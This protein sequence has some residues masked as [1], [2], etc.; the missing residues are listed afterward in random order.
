MSL[1][2]PTVSD[3]GWAVGGDYRTDYGGINV[4]HYCVFISG[5]SCLQP[6]TSYFGNCT[7]RC[8]GYGHGAPPRYLGSAAPP[9]IEPYLLPYIDSGPADIWAFPR[10][11]SDL[12][13]QSA[14]CSHS[15]NPP[16]SPTFNPQGFAFTVAG[17]GAAGF[18]DGFGSAAEFSGPHDVAVDAYGYVYVADTM[19]NAIRGI[20]PHGAV[21]TIAGQGPSSKGYRD[22]NC[23]YALFSQ[24]KGIEVTRSANN[25]TVFVADT[26]NNRIRVIHIDNSTGSCM[27]SCL[28]GLCYDPSKETNPFYNQAT[29]LAGL[30]DG[31]PYSSRFSSPQGIALLHWN[32]TEFIV[33][34]DTGNFL[35]RLVNSSSGYATTLAGNWTEDTSDTPPAGCLAP[36]LVGVAGRRDGN[37]S[38][39]QFYTPQYV[40]I[41]SNATVFVT[42]EHRIR[43]IQ[44]PSTLSD[45][46]G[47]YS[48]GGVSTIAGTSIQGVEDGKGIESS[49][50]DPTGIFVTSDNV[51]YV[52]DAASC[53]IRRVSPISLVAT[54]INCS[55]NLDIVFRPS[56]CTSYDP[57]VD[58]T[59][60]KISRV[61][62]NTIYNYGFP[63]SND[64]D[65]GKYIKDC[66]GSP[67]V[68]LL[69]KHYLYVSGDN[70]V[71]DDGVRVVDEDAEQGTAI[72][73]QC[74]P[75]CLSDSTVV[76]GK[77]VY[78]VRSSICRAGIH[79]GV[80][81][82]QGGI[83][84]VI[85]GR[86]NSS[87]ANSVLGATDNGISSK[88][89]APFEQRVFSLSKE[90]SATSFVHSIAGQPAA[91][92][93]DG[94]GYDDG[95]PAT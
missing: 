14:A 44:L 28:S 76:E 52:S 67:P 19:N 5:G 4:S 90:D 1:N 39:A 64:T 38:Y 93:Q 48:H 22:G 6:E 49:F 56:G 23:S 18:K 34:A 42:D 59:G 70:L 86:I 45:F 73:V 72:F 51:A 40:S 58:L 35:I 69:N 80:I 24:P 53:H 27:V 85:L 77:G 92:L 8:F 3:I 31:P 71:V 75:G 25:I 83:L 68:S 89:L 62:A 37:L 15:V 61:E 26:G 87:A 82:D 10:N 88:P 33:V 41:G 47:Y 11:C 78:S 65:R 17:S 2:I 54:S 57:A 79:N 94:C 9:L 43:M 36:C 55:T 32:S 29:P 84:S 74:P 50:Y 21:T 16:S 46:Y 63:Y 81:D 12:S 7:V 60:R 95:Q 66:V 20:D 30:S 91:D 13:S